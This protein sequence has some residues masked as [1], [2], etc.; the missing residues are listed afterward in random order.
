MNSIK[1]SLKTIY[2]FLYK[3]EKENSDSQGRIHHCIEK[4]RRNFLQKTRYEKH[5]NLV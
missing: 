3:E 1:Y 4:K 2:I 5:W